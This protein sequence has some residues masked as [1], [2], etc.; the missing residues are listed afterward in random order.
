[1]TDH[2][3]M[4]VEALIL[5]NEAIEELL[6]GAAKISCDLGLIND[7]LVSVSR[8]IAGMTKTEE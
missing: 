7:A 3:K 4:I 8:L 1:M 5:A 6:P 2:D